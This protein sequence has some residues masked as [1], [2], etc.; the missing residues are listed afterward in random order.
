MWGGLFCIQSPPMALSIKLWEKVLPLHIGELEPQ[1]H[2]SM[3]APVGRKEV[4]EEEGVGKQGNTEGTV[5]KLFLSGTRMRSRRNQDF[6]PNTTF[7][8]VQICCY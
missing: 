1:A 2:S 6:L 4:R 7:L 3:S 8:N 5:R